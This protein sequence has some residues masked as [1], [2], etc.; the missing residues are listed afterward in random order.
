MATLTLKYVIPSNSTQIGIWLYKPTNITINWGD[1]T[2]NAGITNSGATQVT[3]TYSS[4]GTYN[5]SIGSVGTFSGI[6]PQSEISAIGIQYLTEVTDFGSDSIYTDNSSFFSAFY[7]ASALTK[8]PN[9]FPSKVTI[10]QGM[11]RLCTSFNQ[12]ISVWDVKNVK[13]TDAMFFGSTAFSQN[14]GSWNIG[15][16]EVAGYMFN[17]ATAMTTDNY[18]N[19]LSGWSGQSVKSSVVLNNSPITYSAAGRSG[20]LALVNAP[21]NWN[22]SATFVATYSPTTA[23]SGVNFTVVYSGIVQSEVGVTYSFKSS[24]TTYSTFV[25][26]GSYFYTFNNVKYTGLGATNF[27]IYN[28]DNTQINGNIIILNF[29]LPSIVCFKEDSKILTDKGYVA[30]QDLKKGDLVKTLKDGFVPINAIG[31]RHIHHVASKKR[32]KDQLYQCSK[33]KYPELFEDLVITGCHS[34]LVD[35]F[36]SEEQLNRAIEI[37]GKIFITDEKY[38]VPAAADHRASVYKV[39]GE[40]TIYHFALEN[41]DYYMNYGVYANGLLVETCSKRYLK[42]LSNMELL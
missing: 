29:S 6:S 30:V 14:L 11:L 21:N 12:D 17:G 1:L 15:S 8:V 9:T 38:R 33:E 7:G 22:I 34:I 20:Y 35:S 40:H 18:N 2:S 28:Q 41:D 24:G 31:K 32:I 13:N 26:N 16:L 25:G 23:F 4:A 37:N 5:V 39:A 3:H 36:D 42:E 27:S 19:L 10:C